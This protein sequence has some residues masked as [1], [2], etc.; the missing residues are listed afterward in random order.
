ML[1]HLQGAAFRHAEFNH[2]YIGV[3]EAGEVAVINVKIMLPF[4]NRAIGVFVKVF[5]QVIHLS[6]SCQLDS[7]R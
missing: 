4:M 1:P 5:F 6:I 7:S 3:S 2:V